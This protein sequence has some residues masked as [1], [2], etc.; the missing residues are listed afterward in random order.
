MSET[1]QKHLILILAREFA[2]KLATAAFIT[3]GEG[4]LVYYN[5]QAETLLGR[6]FAEAGEMPAEE[7][8]NLFAIEHLD[9]RPMTLEEMPEGIALLERRPAHD[10]CRITSLDGHHRELAVTA[11]PLFARGADFVGTVIFFWEPSDN[12]N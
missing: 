4:K 1:G 10:A 11:F 6:G 12:G 5:E 7:W 9:G 3:D 8:P 2:S